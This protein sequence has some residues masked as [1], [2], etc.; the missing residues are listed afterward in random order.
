MERGDAVSTGIFEGLEGI[1]P[2]EQAESYVPSDQAYDPSLVEELVGS[3]LEGTSSA[4]PWAGL[5]LHYTVFSHLFESRVDM[6]VPQLECTAN[7]DAQVFLDSVVARLAGSAEE[8]QLSRSGIFLGPLIRALYEA[9]HPDLVLDFTSFGVQVEEV[10]ECLSGTEGRPLSLACLLSR[11]AGGFDAGSVGASA[12]YCRIDIRGSAR[13]VGAFSSDCEFILNGPAGRIGYGSRDCT[14]RLAG[15]ELL[16][17]D[18]VT[19]K[20]VTDSEHPNYH[21]AVVVQVEDEQLFRLTLRRGEGT[22]FAYLDGAFFDGARGNR[23]LV[24]DGAGGWTEVRP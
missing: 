20:K 12:R 18:A 3:Y 23:L 10:A 6:L 13:D 24:P 15:A 16:G 2:S 9:G 1:P 5:D 21:G 11:N 4:S 17:L 19:A 22:A 8:Q 14:Y 7:L